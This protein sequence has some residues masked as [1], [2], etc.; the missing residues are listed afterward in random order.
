LRQQ[1]DDISLTSDEITKLKI[2][3]AKLASGV[4][5]IKVGG[6]TELEMVERKYRIED[7]LNATR[8]AAEE[9]IVPGGGIALFNSLEFLNTSFHED[10]TQ[11]VKA[12]I[13]IVQDACLAPI[14]RITQN[15]G[16]TPEVTIRELQRLDSSFKSFSGYDA[17]NDKFVDMIQTGIIDP[18]K[19][20]RTAL[21]N[22][23]S[24]A[25]TFL[26]LDAVIVEEED[27]S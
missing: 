23:A 25:T 20:T 5:V 19:V 18:V 7:A 26:A 10:I 17:S 24:V 3:I 6:A 9:G 8:A 13:S 2:R 27:E 4:A 1:L 11:G 12:G 15:A 14:R 22:A 21:K 16:Q